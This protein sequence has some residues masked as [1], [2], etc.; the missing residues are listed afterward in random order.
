[1]DAEEDTDYI[2][3]ID[4]QVRER[5][6]SSESI[7]I[8]DEVKAPRLANNINNL[9]SSFTR[10]ASIAVEAI[11]VADFKCEVDSFHRSFT[12]RKYGRQYVEAHHLV[13][14]KY[15]ERFSEA[16]LDVHA[17]IVALCPN[18]HRLLHH[19]IEKEYNIFLR[20]LLESRKPRL[21]RC[22]IDIDFEQLIRLY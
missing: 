6:H 2:E 9:K 22:G 13:P 5:N 7:Q 1:M 11:I 14:M 21:A 20:T 17:N 8:D 18:C 15:Q 3:E 12:S 19:G 10:D 4:E 16:S